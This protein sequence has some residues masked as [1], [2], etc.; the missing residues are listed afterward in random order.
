MFSYFVFALLYRAVWYN[1]EIFIAFC[2]QHTILGSILLF[3]MQQMLNKRPNA[4]PE[5][6]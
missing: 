6:S 2:N 3:F 5:L 4:A 1:P